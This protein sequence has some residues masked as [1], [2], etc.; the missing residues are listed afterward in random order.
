MSASTELVD[1][2]SPDSTLSTL[3]FTLRENDF[4][5]KLP[6]DERIAMI[7]QE[8]HSIAREALAD[9]PVSNPFSYW[10]D[11]EGNLYSHHSK[12]DV[13][14]LS[15][16]KDHFFDTRERGNLPWYGFNEAK[17]QIQAHENTVVLLYSPIGKTDF[18]QDYLEPDN[19]E[20]IR[21]NT[22]FDNPYRAIGEYPDG[23]LYLYYRTGEKINGL[24]L[25][26]SSNA[27]IQQFMPE[28]YEYAYQAATEEEYIARFMLNPVNTHLTIDEF[29]EREWKNES[30]YTTKKGKTYTVHDVLEGARD[31]LAGRQKPLILLNKGVIEDLR[32]EEIATNL[33]LKTYLHAIHD[34]ALS[35]G[36]TGSMSLSGS[37]GGKEVDINSIEKLLGIVPVSELFSPM[38]SAIR[39]VIQGGDLTQLLESTQKP[40]VRFTGEREVNCV[41]GK[42][43][44]V[45]E[46]NLS[47]GKLSCS[48]GA[49][50]SNKCDVEAVYEGAEAA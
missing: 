23:Q 48:C 12:K 17:N 8:I 31:A 30:M 25:K 4:L 28:T 14:R 50:L 18:E 21:E 6:A 15:N 33:I 45:T 19:D 49:E 22:A 32:R 35:Q 34:Y 41:C 3:G 13:Y 36:I 29:L 47:Q 37:C 40:L 5:N 38:S 7:T 1:Y 39:A 24:A 42:K 26:S 46:G 27:L 43:V 2:L 16:G 9:E 20:R 10:F 44:K 11:T